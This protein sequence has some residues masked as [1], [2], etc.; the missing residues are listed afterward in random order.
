[1]PRVLLVGLVLAAAIGCENKRAARPDA[2]AQSGPAAAGDAPRLEGKKEVGGRGEKE[3]AEPE[4]KIIYTARIEL[5]VADLEAARGQL[6]AL[7]A[8]V[9]GYVAKSDEGGRAGGV[10]TGTWRVRVPVA[11]FHDF[12]ARVQGFGELVN[13]SSDAQDVTE[14]FVDT[15]AR[16]R[17]LKAEEAVLNKLLQE[18]AQST[19]DLLAFRQQITQVR[20]QI[21]R[22]QA[23]L[24]TLS[25]LT[26]MTTVEIVMREDKSFVPESAPSFGTTIG[27][28]FSDS[29]STLE[30]FGKWLVLTV[31][32]LA[33][34]LPLIL[35]GLWLARR[36]V[37][38][39]LRNRPRREPPAVPRPRG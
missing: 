31:V 15:E 19:A 38:G 16:L 21:E 6:D 3:L 32:A 1:M 34:W 29:L 12:L 8:E 13:K 26:A 22:Y 18:K 23:R 25:R 30:S 27:R 5:R 10:R 28:T 37:R 2:A 9:K 11:K 20:E 36:G 14:E 7:L 39:A 35:L 24:D 4:R 33:P 17:N